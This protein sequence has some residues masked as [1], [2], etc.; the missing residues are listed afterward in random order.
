V[1]A[2]APV[3]APDIPHQLPQSRQAP[4]ASPVIPAEPEVPAEPVVRAL[5]RDC[6]SPLGP[7]E[8]YCGICGSPAGEHPHPALPVPTISAPAAVSTCASCGSPVAEKG[9]FCGVCGT[10]INSIAPPLPLSSPPRFTPP[11]SQQPSQHPETRL[12]RSCGNPVKPGDKFC[13]KCLAK[14]VDDSMI[15]SVPYQ[16]PV[17]QVLPPSPPSQP[18]ALPSRQPSQPPGTRLCRSCG[19]PVKPGDKFCSN[20]LAK[21]VDDPMATQ[22][23]HQPPAFQVQSPTPPAFPMVCA[24]CGSPVTGTEKFCGIC[25]TPVQS[26]PLASSAH[27]QPV[28]KTCT[29]C[30]S[31]V[32]AT[33]KFC[34]GC[35][36]AVLHPQEQ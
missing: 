22:V 26:A 21:V 27:P 31:P 17:S 4:T 10:S 33:T 18:T 1:S 25:G 16:A 11:S 8:K 9:K 2:P 19:N 24:S 30:G 35:G 3:S 13:S 29:I 7:D 34:G 36:A 5:C 6:G 12:C 28:G 20:C 32:S 14:V 15:A 23:Q